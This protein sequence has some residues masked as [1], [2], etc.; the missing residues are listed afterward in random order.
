MMKH[1]CR[2]A[3][4]KKMIKDILALANVW[5]IR[6]MG[7]APKDRPS[8]ALRALVYILSQ[9]IRRPVQVSKRG[10]KLFCCT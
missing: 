4:T 9:R 6:W 3:R 7:L 2:G 8:I 5:E 10:L 1:K